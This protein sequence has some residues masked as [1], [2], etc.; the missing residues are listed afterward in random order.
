MQ[1]YY[2]E[3]ICSSQYVVEY[4]GFNYHHS[5]GFVYNES[6]TTLIR[7]HGRTVPCCH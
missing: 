2:K 1:A 4:E 7:R 3:T 6:S 5:E